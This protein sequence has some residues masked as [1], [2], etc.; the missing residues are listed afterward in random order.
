MP[1]AFALPMRNSRLSK[2]ERT[3]RWLLYSA[4]AL[5]TPSN[6]APIEKCEFDGFGLEVDCVEVVGI[7][8][9]SH[10]DANTAS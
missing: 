1:I 6:L 3:L 4:F 2:R 7:S 10:G 5:Q 8:P 9:A